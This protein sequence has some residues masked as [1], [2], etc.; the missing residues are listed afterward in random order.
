M[1]P[2]R[3]PGIQVGEQVGVAN[4]AVSKSCWAISVGGQKPQCVA[5][6][7]LVNC[8]ANRVQ[9]VLWCV[10]AKNVGRGARGMARWF[11]MSTKRVHTYQLGSS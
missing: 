6:V 9:L 5:D 4:G 2:Q 3:S 11:S 7:L 10:K 8:C 1:R